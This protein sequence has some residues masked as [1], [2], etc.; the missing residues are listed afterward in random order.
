MDRGG[1]PFAFVG[2]QRRRS[3][4]RRR[5]GA[6]V[7]VPSVAILGTGHMGGAMVGTLRRAGFDV[8]VWNRTRSR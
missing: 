6:A 7:S 2:E 4:R 8:A 1:T 3:L 5:Q